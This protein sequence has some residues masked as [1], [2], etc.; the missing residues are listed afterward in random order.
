MKHTHYFVFIKWR[1][2]V[3]L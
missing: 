3:D 1:T 2:H